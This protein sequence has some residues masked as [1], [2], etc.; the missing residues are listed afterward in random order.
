ME[1]A[2]S[3][4]SRVV[5][6][7]RLDEAPDITIGLFPAGQCLSRTVSPRLFS[8]TQ[9]LWSEIGFDDTMLER[10][11]PWWA[12]LQLGIRMLDLGE[13]KAEWGIDRF[14]WNRAAIDNKLIGVL[15]GT[16]DALPIFN[17]APA[18]EQEGMLALI[19]QHKEEGLRHVFQMISGWKSRRIEPFVDVLN[20][21]LQRL[22]RLYTQLILTR[23][24]L[25]MPRL[26]D[27]IGDGVPTLV[28][29]GGLHFAEPRCVQALFAERGY[30]VS[31]TG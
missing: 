16:S 30:T 7:C 13:I 17:A 2:Y 5:F 21:H 15:E 8:E 23:N 11:R 12:G 1:Q 3:T 18:H 27:F 26:L 22:P 6:E 10:C 4:A 9:Q 25:W 20:Y 19:V 29:A 31:V 14:F 24:E 28:I